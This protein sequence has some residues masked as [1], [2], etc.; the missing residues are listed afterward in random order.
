MFGITW[1]EIWRTGIRADIHYSKFDSDFARGNYKTLSLS[2]H[3]ANRMMWDAQLGSQDLNSPFTLN[4]RSTFVNTSI[5]TNFTRRT[6]LQSGYTFERGST[7]NYRQWYL[8]LGYRFDE[9]EPGK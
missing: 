4:Q 1:N 9:K 6:F 3:L 7:L 5:D 2:R 8:S